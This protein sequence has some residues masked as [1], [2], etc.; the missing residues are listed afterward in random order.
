MEKF[1]IMEF[2]KYERIKS[3]NREFERYKEALI[4]KK[5]LDDIIDEELNSRIYIKDIIRKNINVQ[6]GIA[7]FFSSITFHPRASGEESRHVKIG[8]MNDDFDREW[9]MFTKVFDKFSIVQQGDKKFCSISIINQVVIDSFFELRKEGHINK[10]LNDFTLKG[11]KKDH[12]VIYYKLKYQ[13]DH[14]L[15][16]IKIN[17]VA[18]SMRSDPYFRYFLDEN[19]NTFDGK[20]AIPG[21][22]MEE[23]KTNENIF[24][25]SKIVSVLYVE[26]IDGF[27][28]LTWDL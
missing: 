1:E 8:L 9:D 12:R 14:H 27:K 19:I 4:N 16:D 22:T 24:A 20:I 11:F 23:I 21:F 18:D 26:I 15:A 2:N 7:D 3:F 13:P 10:W 6:I 25:F 28:Y 17:K 5:D